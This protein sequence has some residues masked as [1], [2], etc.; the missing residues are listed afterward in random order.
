MFGGVNGTCSRFF[1]Y[2]YL[3][4]CR[5]NT[6]KIFTKSSIF[7]LNYAMDKSFSTTHLL[8]QKQQTSHFSVSFGKRLAVTCIIGGA[9]ISV[10][11]YLQQ[12][13]KENQKLQRFQQLK[14]LAV[15]QG[16]F[17]LV[18]HTGHPRSK[19]DLRGKWVLLY[20]GFTH[21]P[22]ICPDELQKMIS[23]VSLLEKDSLLPPVLPVFITVDPERD[24]VEA[25]AKYVSEFHPRLLGLTGSTEQ[26]KQ[27]AQAY[28]V[29]YSAGPKDEDNDYIVDHTIIIYLLNPDGLF[30]DYFNRGKTDQE[31]ADS[32]R[33]HM[34]TYTSLFE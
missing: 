16:D 7:H 32:V 11:M 20:F 31:I 27:A 2:Q 28:R 9:A 24:N 33:R 18:D 15:G 17:R 4:T 22:D 34:N 25:L 1:T 12:E 21:C 19:K 10:W 13:K 5:R 8:Y 26:V 29:Y 6:S 14:N 30:T 23:A 3:L